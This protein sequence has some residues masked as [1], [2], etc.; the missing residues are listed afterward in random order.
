MLVI[1]KRTVDKMGM[2][3]LCFHYRM[4]DISEELMIRYICTRS[5]VCND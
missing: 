2:T 1:N 4:T 5:N 3:E